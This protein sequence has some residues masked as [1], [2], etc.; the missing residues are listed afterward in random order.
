LSSDD[1]PPDDLSSDGLPSDDLPSDDARPGDLPPDGFSF[2]GD[3]A[4]PQ[5]LYSPR[6]SIGWE[7]YTNDRLDSE[8][9]RCATFEQDLVLLIIA[10]TEPGSSPDEKYRHLAD[11]AVDFFNLRDLIFERGD[12]GITVIL[13]NADLDQG[14]AEAEDFH[15]HLATAFNAS[16]DFR[17]GISSRAGRLVDAER[18][19]KEAGEALNKAMHDPVSPIVAFKSD[20]EKYRAFIRSKGK[21]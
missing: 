15:N 21:A 10:Y 4:Q 3:D 18:L 6:S 13:P 5:G 1:L 2:E 8:L 20:P 19:L 11:T 14:F 12:Q 17:V 16:S 9:H 7:D